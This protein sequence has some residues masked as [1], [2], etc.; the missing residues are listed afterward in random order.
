MA[1]HKGQDLSAL[2]IPR[3]LLHMKY[4]NEAHRNSLKFQASLANKKLG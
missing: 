3:V 4:F 1:Y 2:T